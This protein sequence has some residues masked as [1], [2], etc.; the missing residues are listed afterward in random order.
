MPIPTG[1]ATDIPAILIAATI[2][3]LAKLNITPPKNAETKDALLA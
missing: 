1:K 3:R 2:K